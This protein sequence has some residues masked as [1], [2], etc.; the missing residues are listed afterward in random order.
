MDNTDKF[1]TAD[2]MYM[3]RALQLA[4]NGRGYVSPNPMVGAVIVAPDGRIIGEGWH[5]RYGGPHAE[6][7]AVN[8]VAENGR[9]LLGD[10]TIYVTL[11]PCSHYGKTPPCAKLLTDICIGRVVVG[12][13]DPNPKV[14]G[15]GVAMLREAGIT[16]DEGLLAD[17]CRALNKTFMTAHTLH[18]PF[19]TL[20]WAQSAD[21]FMDHKRNE[22][23]SAARFS[24]PLTSLIVHDRRA[25][26]DA[27]AVGARTV[28]ADRPRLDTRLVAGRSPIRIVFDRRGIA[29]DDNCIHIT[30]DKPLADVLE[31]LYKDHNI[32]SLLVEGGASLLE[33][34]I[35]PDSLDGQSLWDEAYVEVSPVC[36]GENG[37]V[38]APVLPSDLL[39]DVVEIDGN[40]IY[41]FSN[42]N[43]K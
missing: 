12:A 1:S 36:L 6:V 16:V 26:H 28:I 38:K 10:S 19:V 13:G 31:N 20:K 21:G 15:R 24:T 4:A 37:T 27:I 17:E 14:S 42:R 22:G 32:T 30:E 8:S 29:N 18:R 25:T 34:F 23:E 40:K 33:S 39:T 11:E 43:V 41:R 3:R 5:R 35:H 2:C 7:N 9:R